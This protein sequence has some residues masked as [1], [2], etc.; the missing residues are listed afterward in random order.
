MAKNEKPISREERAARR[1]EIINRKIEQAKL[2]D[3]RVVSVKTDD[4]GVAINLLSQTDIAMSRL[5][6]QIGG[7]IDAD[8]AITVISN[9]EKLLLAIESFTKE[10]CKITDS[11]YMQQNVLAAIAK[12]YAQNEE[13]EK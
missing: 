3:S 12:K 9:F 10:L 2:P 8:T 1:N 6:R 4:V 7:K 11:R 13:K 5:R